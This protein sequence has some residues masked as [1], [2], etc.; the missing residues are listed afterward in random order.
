MFFAINKKSINDD[1]LVADLFI[2]IRLSEKN[3]WQPKK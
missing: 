1:S 2:A 3:V